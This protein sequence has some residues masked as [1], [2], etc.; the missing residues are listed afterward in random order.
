[1]AGFLPRLRAWVLPLI[2][3]V[4]ALWWLV[5]AAPAAAA[6]LQLSEVTIAP[7]PADDPGAQPGASRSSS[8]SCYALRGVVTNRG[9]RAVVDTDV[10]A[11]ILDAGGEPVLPHRGRIGSL[12]DVPPGTSRFALRLAVPPGSR[13]PLQVRN[14][15]ARGFTSPVRS[16]VGVDEERLPLE[17]AL[18][19]SRSAP[20]PQ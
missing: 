12:G 2:P 9:R 20:S 17:M 15:K 3:L 4:V 7:C 10:F 5:S 6:D 8:A 14:A 13:T 16:R 18:E 19:E 11:L 1:M